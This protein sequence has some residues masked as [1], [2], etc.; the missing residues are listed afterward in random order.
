MLFAGVA[1]ACPVCFGDPSAPSAKG[2]NAAIW[3]LL[4]MVGFIQ[5]GFAALFVTFWRRARALR[6]RKESF[7]LIDG[8]AR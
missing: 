4:G 6:Q 2:M 5:A 7:Q 8:G 1:N 3:F